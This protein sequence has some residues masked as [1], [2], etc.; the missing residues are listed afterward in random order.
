MRRFGILAGLLLLLYG[1]LAYWKPE[2]TVSP[3]HLL[4]GH[5]EV[6]SECRTCHTLFR[7]VKNAGCVTCHRVEEIGISTVSGEPL[8]EPGRIPFHS[9]LREGSCIA[10]HTDHEG[11]DSDGT[12]TRFAHELLASSTVEACADCHEPQRP[13]DAIHRAVESECA[14]C[15]LSAAWKPAT[16]EHE[17]YFRFDPH[18]PEDCGT[19]HTT[20]GDLAAYTCYGCHEHTPQKIRAEHLEE[21]IEEFERCE[22]CHRSSDEEEAERAWRRLRREERG[23]M[24]EAL[25]HG[26]RDDDEDDDDDWDDDE[27]GDDDWDD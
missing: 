25:G 18:H 12:G 4:E 22:T 10:C 20:P 6:E 19:C 17:R 5:A 7:G 11:R 15:H 16:F 9:G 23:P 2:V 3:G 26:G 14:S 24:G 8:R 21:G 1:G 27:D 13:S